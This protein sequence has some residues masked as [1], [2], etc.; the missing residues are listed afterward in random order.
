MEFAINRP[1]SSGLITPTIHGR[2]F[3]IA[4]EGDRL[5]MKCGEWLHS[6]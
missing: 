4:L 3:F 2:G 1:D 6:G 5:C